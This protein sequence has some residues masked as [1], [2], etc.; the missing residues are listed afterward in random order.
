M[1]KLW[2]TDPKNNKKSVTLTLMVASF[3]L[4]VVGAGAMIAG[5]IDNIGPLLEV[6]ITNTVLYAGRRTKLK[7]KNLKIDQEGQ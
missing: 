7:T 3:I 4:L 5:Y 1:D 6:Y 2:L